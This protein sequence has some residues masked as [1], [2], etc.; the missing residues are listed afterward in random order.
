M[1][2]TQRECLGADDNQPTGAA[3]VKPAFSTTLESGSTVCSVIEKVEVITSSHRFSRPRSVVKEQEL[4]WKILYH[5]IP[6]SSKA[7]GYRLGSGLSKTKWHEI[8]RTLKTLRLL[9]GKD[10]G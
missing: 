4:P 6:R 9:V 7:R 10:K 3:Q 8:K 2:C 5:A 1:D